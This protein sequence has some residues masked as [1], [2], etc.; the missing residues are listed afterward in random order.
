MVSIG[1]EKPGNGHVD[2]T[3]KT[4]LYHAFLAVTNI[5]FAYGNTTHTPNIS[6]ALTNSSRSRCVLRFHLRD[7]KAYRL[8]ENS[9]HVAIY[10]HCNVHR[11]C[12]GHLSIRRCRR[13]IPR[14]WVNQSYYEQDCLW[15]CHSNCKHFTRPSQNRNRLTKTRL[16]LLVSSTAT[17]HANTSTS[18]S[19]VEPITC[20]NAAFC[21][22][23]R[24]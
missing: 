19:S 8:S 2:A 23:E 4:N 20:R 24:G 1:I 14:A 17:L 18:E 15:H 22:W 10:R 9:I 16:S 6:H 11:G 12:R 5:V 21:Q 3:V 7:E 13:C